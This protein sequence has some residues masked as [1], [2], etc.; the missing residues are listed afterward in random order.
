MANVNRITVLA[1]GLIGGSLAKALRE[2]N[3]AN[4]IVGWGRKEATLKRAI[5]LGAIDSY[6]LDLATA[7]KG[8]DIGKSVV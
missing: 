2:N 8:S 6:D 1:V 3:F 7:V 4:E 5:E